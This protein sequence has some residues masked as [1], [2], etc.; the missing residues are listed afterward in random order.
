LI[1]VCALRHV[2]TCWSS[3]LKKN[4]PQPEPVIHPLQRALEGAIIG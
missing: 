4:H 2:I 1:T 3:W